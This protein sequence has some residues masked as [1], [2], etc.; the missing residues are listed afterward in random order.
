MFILSQ[1]FVEDAPYCNI[2]PF[3]ISQFAIIE[4]VGLLIEITE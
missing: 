1:P 2:E 3:T 4:A